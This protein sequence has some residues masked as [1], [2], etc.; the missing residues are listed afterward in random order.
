MVL[1]LRLLL[2]VVREGGRVRVWRV[3]RSRALRRIG[4]IFIH[5]LLHYHNNN[6]KD[7]DKDKDKGR[8]MLLLHLLRPL[9]Q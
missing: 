1:L 7:K 9:L 3:M 8:D 2:V 4:T 5:R 6:N